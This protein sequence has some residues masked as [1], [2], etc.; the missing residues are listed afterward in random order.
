MRGGEPLA[1]G[2]NEALPLAMFVHATVPG[3]H[4]KRP[5][6]EPKDRGSLLI[7]WSTGGK[8]LIEFIERTRNLRKDIRIVVVAG[9]V[10]TDAVMQE[11]ALAG[12]IEQHGVHIGALRLSENKFTGFKGTDTGHR[13]FNTTHMA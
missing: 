6:R 10:Q 3:R 1:L 13:L 2:L 5:Y 8:T 4:S 12:A 11:H 9:V 7:P